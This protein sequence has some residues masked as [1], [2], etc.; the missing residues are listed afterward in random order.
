MGKVGGEKSGVR[1]GGLE[2]EW[3]G[4]GGG[5][6]DGFISVSELLAQVARG[7][8]LLPGAPLPLRLECAQVAAQRFGGLAGGGEVAAE[9][10]HRALSLCARAAQLHAL[11]ARLD[12]AGL[13][14]LH[15]RLRGVSQY[16]ACQ[17]TR[18][19]DNVHVPAGPA[20]PPPRPAARVLRYPAVRAARARRFP[21][22]PWTPARRHIQT[23]NVR[24]SHRAHAA[25]AAPAPPAAGASGC[26]SL[27]AA[28]RC[29]PSRS[30]R[31]V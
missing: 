23:G 7:D 12:Q 18:R 10:R 13:K 8:V 5:A 31:R 27:C 24:G 20:C 21:R 28:P 2:G 4:G 26:R 16:A 14:P 11:S 29:R 19:R 17:G 25:H 22:Q 3:G 30:L 15:V 9:Q 1:E 6:P